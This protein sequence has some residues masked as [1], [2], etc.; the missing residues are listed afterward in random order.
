MRKCYNES[1]NSITTATATTAPITTTTTIATFTAINKN[2]DNENDNDSKY[3]H[4]IEKSTHRLTCPQPYFVQ[5]SQ[6]FRAT[7][8]P[9]AVAPGCRVGMLVHHCHPTLAPCQTVLPPLH[10]LISLFERPCFQS[11]LRWS[12][13]NIYKNKEYSL[14]SN[15][16]TEGI[17]QNKHLKKQNKARQTLNIN[18]CTRLW[19]V[20]GTNNSVQFSNLKIHESF[21]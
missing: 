15:P 19:G 9:H 20:S 21:R 5:A 8:P 16:K 2:Y 7:Y 17:R 11:R 10:V 3:V 13:G 1:I 18:K 12:R 4:T 6:F 14:S